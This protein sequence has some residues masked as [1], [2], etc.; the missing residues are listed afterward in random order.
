MIKV[1]IIFSIH[2]NNR[3]ISPNTNE[4]HSQ[5]TQEN[6]SNILKFFFFQLKQFIR[7][8]WRISKHYF[9]TYKLSRTAASPANLSLKPLSLRPVLQGA[10]ACL[11]YLQGSSSAPQRS[12]Y[13]LWDSS[14]IS[15]KHGP[16]SGQSFRVK[17]PYFLSKWQI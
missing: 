10:G 9:Q 1:T 15:L 2:M 14:E 12:Q 3:R 4:S 16:S 8:T 6:L 11:G 13:S 5:V 17:N 7:L